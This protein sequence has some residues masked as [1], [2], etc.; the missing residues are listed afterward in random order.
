MFLHGQHVPAI[1]VIQPKVLSNLINHEV[2]GDGDVLVLTKPT[3]ASFLV[4]LADAKDF[5]IK[6][7]DA[8]GVT[9]PHTD[10]NVTNNTFTETGHG[11]V[12]GYG[13]V[14]VSSST[15]LPTGLA[16]TTPYWVIYVDANTF[17]L[18]SSEA[19]AFA[20]VAIDVTDQGS[21]N[22]TIAVPMPAAATPGADV[23]NGTGARLLKEGGELVLAGP[24]KVSIKA[25]VASSV[26][27]YYWL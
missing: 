3:G 21:G 11:F 5:R 4:L 20:G 17:K 2:M 13:P 1:D 19:N 26:L 12:T 9:F 15:T 24:N 25:F 16:A 18:A 7:G 6:L 23:T 22:H 10:V 8:T 27:T 14:Y